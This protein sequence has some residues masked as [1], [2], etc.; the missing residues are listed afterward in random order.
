VSDPAAP[1]SDREL[2]R[3]I[4]AGDRKAGDELVRRYEAKV[5]KVVYGFTRDREAA[6][7]LVQDAFLQMFRKLDY[8]R[9][10]YEFS[11]WFY[12]L[13]INLAINYTRRRK[14]IGWIPFSRVAGLKESSDAGSLD[15]DSRELFG[16]SAIRRLHKAIAMLPEK[17]RVAIT[18]FDLEGFSIR[19]VAEIA[20]CSEGTVMSRLFYGRKRLKELI[21]RPGKSGG[22]HPGDKK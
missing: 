19:E 1:L 6:R 5:F 3:R 22:E 7:D 10:E 17:Q 11:T 13:V 21:A 9:E 16:E 14:L 20:G 8:Y 18:L 2:V 12:R 4:T 15:G